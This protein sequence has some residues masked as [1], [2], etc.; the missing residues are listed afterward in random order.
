MWNE[1][2]FEIGKLVLVFQTRMGNMS[3]KLRFRW[4]G[5]FFITREYN[6]SYQ[7][8]M[9]AGELL[10]K[11]VNGF[12]LKPY[13]GQIPENPFRE[14]ENPQNMVNQRQLEATDL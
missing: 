6:G 10:R 9:L 12:L 13:K 4:T 2:E 7:L 5:P 1:K 3:G 8:G 14:D 11:W